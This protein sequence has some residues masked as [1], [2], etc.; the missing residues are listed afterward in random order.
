MQDKTTVAP[1]AMA[2][3]VAAP[4][5][6]ALFQGYDSVTGRGLGTVLTGTSKKSGAPRASPT[7]SVPTSRP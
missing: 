4:V 7:G 5:P 1:E 6:V 3:V 2:K